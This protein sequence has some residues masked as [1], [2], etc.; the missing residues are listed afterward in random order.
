MGLFGKTLRDNRG[1]IIGMG[2][3]NALIALF[4][5]L[6]YPSFRGA[7]AD[8]QFPEF[9]ASFFGEGGVA[10]YTTFEGFIAVEL[11][12]W[13]PI[14]LIVMV[15]IGGTATLAGEEGA[16]TLDLLLAQP[17]ARRR[18]VL[19]KA[20]GLTVAI[21]IASLATLAGLL[22]GTVLIDVTVPLG[23]VALAVV[24]MLPLTLLFLG[25]SLWASA[26]LASR[27]AAAMLVAGLTVVTYFFNL[28]GGAVERVEFLRKL[29]PFYWADASHVMLHGFDW[30][31]TG[32][33]LLL[34]AAFVALALWSFERRDIAVGARR[35]WPR[36]SLP[37]LSGRVRRRDVA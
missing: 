31:R 5:V 20:A 24:N 15:I 11:F 2:I 18:L 6:A 13:L 30:L 16:G 21:A 7:L 35:W 3:A 29:S 23:R 4:V 33:F 12:T 27:G 34:A 19:E 26:A 14:L 9:L 17:V 32:G 36:F 8:Y 37:R 28:I 22:A 25:L 1:A 10:A